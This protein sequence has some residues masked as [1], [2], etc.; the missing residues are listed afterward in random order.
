[1]VKLICPGGVESD[2][3]TRFVWWLQ[4]R[5]PSKIIQFNHLDLAIWGEWKK[6]ATVTQFVRAGSRTQVSAPSPNI[7]PRH[8]APLCPEE[9]A[10]ETLLPLQDSLPG[11][12]VAATLGGPQ[13][14]GGVGYTNR[15][16]C[17]R[18]QAITAVSGNRQNHSQCPKTTLLLK[19]LRNETH[20][21][22]QHWKLLELSLKRSNLMT[23]PSSW[24]FVFQCDEREC[25][26]S[27]AES[28]A[29]CAEAKKAF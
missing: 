3:E 1:M 28:D 10:F 27:T 15:T 12:T 29:L 23:N 26:E 5:L 25:V 21:E 9:S 19:E 17:R 4:T 20:S 16:L 7:S 2:L 18:D 14:P 11:T 8:P 22:Y 13:F 24:Q 6:C